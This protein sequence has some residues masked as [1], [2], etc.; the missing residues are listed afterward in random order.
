MRYQGSKRSIAKH[1]KALIENN[2]LEGQPYVEPFGG[3]MNSFSLIESDFKVA[4]DINPYVISMWMEV[5]HGSFKA[6]RSLTQ[7]EYEDMKTDC[8]NRTGKYKPSLLGYV[9]NACSYG[10]G[11]WN[12]YAKYNPKKNEDHILEAANGFEK[13]IREFKNLRGSFFVHSDYRSYRYCPESFI[14]CDPPYAETKRY[15]KNGFD[16]E[17]FWEWC[18]QMVKDGHKVMVS[19]Y[20]APSDFICIWQKERKDGMGT[21]FS[22]GKQNTKIEKVFVHQSQIKNFKF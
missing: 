6:P 12:G 16:N 11:W 10:G 1:I 9:G 3:G 13:H 15:N 7:E 21:T 22:G 5:R 8:L 17:A 4:L 2:L 19:E 18:R 20:T 14:Y